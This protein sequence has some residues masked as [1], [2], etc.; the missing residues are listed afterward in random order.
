MRTRRRLFAVGERQ[1]I[2]EPAHLRQR[3]EIVL[4]GAVDDA[5]LRRVHARAA[6]FFVGDDL[7][8]HGFHDLGAGDIHVARILHHEDEVGHRRRIDVAARAR[9]HDDADLRDDAGGEDVALEDIGV[10][11]E[12]FHALLN[13]RAAGV[14]NADDWSAVLH[15]HVLDL[16]NLLR[17]RAGER[18]AEDGEVLGEDV[19]QAA[20]DRAPAGDDAVAGDFGFLHAEFVAAV[21]DEHV[22]LLERAF[23]EQKLNA[24]ARRQLAFGVLRRM[25]LLAPALAR[26]FA[27]GFERG[28]NV[29]HKVPELSRSAE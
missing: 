28:D 13:A 11:G 5:R 25:A 16:A 6:E 15:R 26:S 18:A 4:V 1:E 20:V 12:R 21:F 14:E 2:D 24:L 8:R 10:A 22:E 29:F 7:V 19:D 17:V 23:V 9:A 27:L 3:F